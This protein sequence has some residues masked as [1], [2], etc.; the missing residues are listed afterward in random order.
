MPGFKVKKKINKKACLFRGFPV[1]LMIVLIAGLDGRL[2]TS[3]SLW[4]GSFLARPTCESNTNFK[5]LSRITRFVFVS[6]GLNSLVSEKWRIV[7][8]YRY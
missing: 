8:K 4:L 5:Y 2:L 1:Q 3:F 6:G 7:R